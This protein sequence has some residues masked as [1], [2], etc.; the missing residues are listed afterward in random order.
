MSKP[1]KRQLIILQLIRQNPGLQNKD[2]LA[3]LQK[4]LGEKFGRVTIVR[5]IDV[6]LKQNLIKR[7]G[8][9][10]S[11]RYSEILTNQLLKYIDVKSYFDKDVDK[12][13]ISHQ[14]FNFTI[15]NYLK[16]LLTKEEINKLDK[17]NNNYKKRIKNLSPTIIKKEIE[18]LTIDLSWKSSQIEGNTYSLIDTEILIKENKE[19]KGHKKEEAIMILDH[20]KAL[21]FIFSK[22]NS[23]T[24]ISIKDLENLHSLLVAG[25]GVNKGLRKNLV[26]I[27]GTNYK[28]LGNQHQIKEAIEKTLKA[29]NVNKNPIEKSLIAAVMISYIQPF[30]DGN[31]RTSRLMANALLVANGYCPLSFRSVSEKDYKKAMIIFYEQNSLLY[32]KQLFI[33]QFKFSVNNYFL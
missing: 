16:N 8:A 17:L 27:T 25:L 32:F 4:E 9:G 10:R 30:E 1:T 21:D 11:I 33:E 26:G 31:K 18:R 3:Y 2:I 24:K 6:L 13:Q 23:F 7:Q 12:R 20:K 28:P 19:A 5:D 14:N 15:F 22:K 29:I